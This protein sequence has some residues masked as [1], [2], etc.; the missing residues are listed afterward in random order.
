VRPEGIADPGRGRTPGGAKASWRHPLR[1]LARF[2]SGLPALGR[3]HTQCLTMHA[4]WPQVSWP[5][6][7]WTSASGSSNTRCLLARTPASR[8][9]SR[10]TWAGGVS[11]QTRLSSADPGRARTRR[12]SRSL[13]CSST[14]IPM[15]KPSG[16][17][18]PPSAGQTRACVVP[19]RAGGA[20]RP[21]TRSPHPGHRLPGSRPAAIDSVA[22]DRRPTGRSADLGIGNR[23]GIAHGDVS[24][25]GPSL[26][27]RSAGSAGAGLL[28][29]AVADAWPGSWLPAAAG[30]FHRRRRGTC[31]ARDD[32]AGP[33]R[34]VPRRHWHPGR[35][36]TLRLRW[37]PSPPGAGRVS[38]PVV[39][40]AC[41]MVRPP[42]VCHERS[43]SR[44]PG[45]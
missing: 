30:A 2:R 24:R 3:L 34:G 35:G 31:E 27:L 21:P 11:H 23:T 41:Q 38:S 12:R 39:P 43:R 20:G 45:C 10:P 13:H 9:P 5:A 1:R 36:L 4:V 18:R 8:R 37:N 29:R 25:Q 14:S 28:P 15:A 32:P 33:L 19:S 44:A 42:A 26:R 7:H 40:S 17:C 6:N 16:R 22:E